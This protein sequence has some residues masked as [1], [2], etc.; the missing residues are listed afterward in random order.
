MPF[1]DPCDGCGN[2][3]QI[4]TSLN[5]LFLDAEHADVGNLLKCTLCQ[6][7]GAIVD[8]DGRHAVLWDELCGKCESVLDWRLALLTSRIYKQV[9]G[10]DTVSIFG[11]F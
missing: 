10:I 5:Y 8:V 9:K 1:T 7:R 11:E 2:F 4:Y 6:C 3:V